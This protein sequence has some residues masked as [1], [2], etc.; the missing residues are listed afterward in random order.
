MVSANLV[1]TVH[2]FGEGISHLGHNI[3]A[4]F[5]KSLTISGV[6]TKTSKSNSP[7]SIFS[8]KSTLPTIS[9]P[10]FFA[11]S[12]LSSDTKAAILIGLPVP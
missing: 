2:A 12:I 6:V 8:S 1:V 9:A 3:L 10:A 7:F 4:T 5:A 11:S